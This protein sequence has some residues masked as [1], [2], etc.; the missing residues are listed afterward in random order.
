LIKI[1]FIAGD[2]SLIGGI[3]K[4]NRDLLAALQQTE[5][6]ITLVMRNKGGLWEK[7]SFVFRI[8][9]AFIERRPDLIYCA[10]LNFSP[11]CLILNY[12]IKTK[13]AIALYGI[14]IHTLKGWFKKR[15][16]SGAM[17]LVTISDYARSL[18]LEQ[19][20]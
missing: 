3:E 5:A 16:A 17:L 14:E 20:F 10:H 18:I 7:I 13:Y 12:F 2:V 4:Y 15:A 9:V 1:L 8:L 19:L 6:Q 11:T